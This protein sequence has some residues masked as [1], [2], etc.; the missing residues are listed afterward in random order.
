[1]ADSRA[2]LK[3]QFDFQARVP[4]ELSFKEGDIILLIDKHESGMWKGELDGQIGLFP[5][6][7]VAELDGA[8]VCLLSRDKFHI[9]PVD[10]H[11]PTESHLSRSVFPI[12]RVPL[13]PLKHPLL[14]KDGSQSRV[15]FRFHLFASILFSLV[16]GHFMKNWKRRWFVLKDRVLYYYENKVFP[17]ICLLFSSIF[18]RKGNKKRKWRYS[19]L[20]LYC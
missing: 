12:C 16:A 13:V 5:Y 3:A 19:T 18:L 4:N 7:F 11:C 14:P 9:I 6:N 1:M 8:D 10:T 20:W 2:R 15:S 17:F